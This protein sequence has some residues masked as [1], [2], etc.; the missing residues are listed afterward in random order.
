MSKGRVIEL[1]EKSG[2]EEM[3]RK[4]DGNTKNTDDKQGELKTSFGVLAMHFIGQIRK[5]NRR[6]LHIEQTLKTISS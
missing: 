2:R 3:D 5:T 6:H 4:Y 1:V